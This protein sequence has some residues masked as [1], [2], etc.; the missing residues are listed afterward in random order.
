MWLTNGS[1][2]SSK[3]TRTNFESG[4]ELRWDNGSRFLSASR[5]GQTLRWDDGD[6]HMSSSCTN[7]LEFDTLARTIG[8]ALC[9]GTEVRRIAWGIECR[10]I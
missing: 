9:L 5:S 2:D 3:W 8:S 10:F 1:I 4:D 7:I 6:D